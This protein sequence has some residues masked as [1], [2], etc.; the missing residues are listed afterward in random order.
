MNCS[1][2]CEP[3]GITGLAFIE[4]IEYR[5]QAVPVQIGATPVIVD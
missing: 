5:G 1:K 4:R 3:H 2:S